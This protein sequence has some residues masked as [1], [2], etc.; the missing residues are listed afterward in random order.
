M[1]FNAFALKSSRFSVYAI[2]R[3][4]KIAEHP[5]MSKLEME[6]VKGEKKGQKRHDIQACASVRQS[7]YRTRT[8]K[9]H[10]CGILFASN[11]E[12]LCIKF[13]TLCLV[14]YNN[15]FFRLLRQTACLH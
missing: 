14:Y 1:F 10:I 7:L 15:I 9:Y 11:K 3:A 6:G 2:F 13:L 5:I 8:I 12:Y 4:L